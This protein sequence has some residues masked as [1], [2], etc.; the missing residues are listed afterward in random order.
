MELGVKVRGQFVLSSYG[1]RLFHS[2]GAW[3][4]SDEE[5]LL[6]QVEVVGLLSCFL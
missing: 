2:A 3:I 5:E 4:G 1:T 6:G